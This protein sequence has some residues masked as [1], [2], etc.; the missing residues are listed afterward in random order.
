EENQ[1]ASRAA[2]VIGITRYA[3]RYISPEQCMGRPVDERS[4][5]YSLG[6]ILYEAFTG[7]PPFDSVNAKDIMAK[8]LY[9]DPPPYKL[10][11]AGLPLYTIIHQCLEKNPDARYQTA[12]D[13]MRTLDSIRRGEEVRSAGQ[14]F[15]LKRMKHL[16]IAVATL[17][18]I[19]ILV[20][21]G[22]SVSHRINN[23]P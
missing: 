7:Q 19:V 21:F 15:A 23:D 17:T 12:E 14:I 13:L 10:D 20:V 18:A 22:I 5:I 8:H 6:C 16:T 1:T 11:K 2:G 3:A 9:A 4:N